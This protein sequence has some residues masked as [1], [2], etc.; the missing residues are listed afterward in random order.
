M[1]LLLQCLC[2][3]LRLFTG[4][5]PYAMPVACNNLLCSGY[6]QV[7]GAKLV[8]EPPHE[9]LRNPLLD[10]EEPPR[11]L[12]SNGISRHNHPPRRQTA[13]T[14]SHSQTRRS[15]RSTTSTA[16]K[17]SYAERAVLIP[18]GAALTARDRVVSSVNDTLTSYSSTTRAQAQLR[19]FERRG[20]T[21]RKRLERE[22]RK[23]RVRASS[24]KL[25]KRRPGRAPS[26][27]TASRSASRASSDHQLPPPRTR[28]AGGA[29]RRGRRTGQSAGLIPR[30]QK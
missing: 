2:A 5:L 15:T 14:R 10:D 3:E 1:F 27:P 28:R 17:S 11:R 8:V 22:V 13:Q 19:K 30:R 16:T 24:A 29:G 7:F 25:R 21:A 9:P 4:H 23:A 6:K 20:A 26:S 12:P 18:V